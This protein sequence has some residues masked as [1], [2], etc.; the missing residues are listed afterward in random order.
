MVT[1][2]RPLAMISTLPLPV[3]TICEEESRAS[4]TMSSLPPRDFGKATAKEVSN[5]IAVADWVWGNS[6]VS[7]EPALETTARN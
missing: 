2:A 4:T 1:S 6:L 3:A 7:D 5:W